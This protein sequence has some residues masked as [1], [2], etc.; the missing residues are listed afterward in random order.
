M[1]IL[2][3]LYENQI[4][5][6]EAEKIVDEMIERF[7]AG[8]L[9]NSIEEIFQLDTYEYTAWMY[10]ASLRII[11]KWR[12]EGWPKRCAVCRNKLDYK[13]GGWFVEFNRLLHS[14]CP[15]KK[16][17]KQK[18]FQTSIKILCF[19]VTSIDGITEYM[20]YT[21]GNIAINFDSYRK[22]V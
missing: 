14:T 15:S 1:D 18:N 10:G 9:K 3:R 16:N 7:H 13:K 22:K 8:K 11:A 12:Y 17:W 4:S 19:L 20:G 21:A 2:K 5:E 6:K